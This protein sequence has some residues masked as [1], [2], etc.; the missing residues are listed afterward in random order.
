M[1]QLLDK[2]HSSTAQSLPWA[3]SQLP[4]LAGPREQSQGPRA[5]QALA[6]QC[7]PGAPCR[8]HYGGVGE[9]CSYLLE[10]LCH[11]CL[12][13]V[14]GVGVTVGGCVG[15]KL[16]LHVLQSLF[17]LQ[18]L[19]PRQQDTSGPG[20]RDPLGSRVQRGFLDSPGAESIDLCQSAACEA[21][22]NGQEQP[23]VRAVRTAARCAA[24]ALARDR[25]LY[26]VCSTP[27]H[28]TC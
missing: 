5:G 25:C 14:A 8:Q 12:A 10:F 3:A 18:A 11:G 15:G 13:L 7:R 6:A 1:D 22:P 2:Q 16:G 24:T 23:E 4:G 26:G 27:R 20:P 19:K 28:P 17:F 21:S 9:G